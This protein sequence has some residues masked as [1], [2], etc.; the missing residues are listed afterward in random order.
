MQS[1][2][3]TTSRNSTKELKTCEIYETGNYTYALPSAEYTHFSWEYGHGR[4][5]RINIKINEKIVP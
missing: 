1:M 3:D 4:N 5:E 2:P